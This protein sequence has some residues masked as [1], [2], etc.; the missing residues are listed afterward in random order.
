M[1][2]H[3]VMLFSSVYIIIGKAHCSIYKMKKRTLNHDCFVNFGFRPA[4]I[5]LG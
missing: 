1:S 4:H 3:L 2:L 5:G